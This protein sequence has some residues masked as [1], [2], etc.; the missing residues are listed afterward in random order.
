MRGEIRLTEPGG[1]G[2]RHR[3]ER[4]ARLEL[5]HPGAREEDAELRS[6]PRGDLLALG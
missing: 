3:S 5:R 4:W 1:F 2:R 6:E